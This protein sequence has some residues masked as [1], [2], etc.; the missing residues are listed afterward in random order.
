MLRQ[1]GRF[2]VMTSQVTAAS[3]GLALSSRDLNS[4]SLV[5]ARNPKKVRRSFLPKLRVLSNLTQKKIRG[6]CYKQP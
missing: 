2:A 1:E 4:T 5:G 6:V 3:F